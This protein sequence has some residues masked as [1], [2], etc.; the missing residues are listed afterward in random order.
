MKITLGLF[1]LVASVLSKPVAAN[2]DRTVWLQPGGCITVGSQQVCAIRP[3][4]PAPGAGQ[5]PGNVPALPNKMTHTCKNGVTDETNPKLRG[6]AHILVIRAPDGKKI[7]EEVVKTYGP[8]GQKQCE[9]DA[10]SAR[11]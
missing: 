4:V 1:A 10:Q 2:E 3:E 5:Q 11:D 9:A 6:W 7:S 8:L